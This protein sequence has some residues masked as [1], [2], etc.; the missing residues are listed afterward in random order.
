MTAKTNNTEATKKVTYKISSF[1]GL[2]SGIGFISFGTWSLITTVLTYLDTE[3]M[4]SLTKAEELAV[5]D[6]LNQGMLLSA[7]VIAL[8]VIILE[9]Q[10]KNLR[11]E[12][13]K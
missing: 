11:G 8:G 6:Y 12:Q 5:N 2:T 9:L 13:E 3:I 4:D 1:L 10:D 7:I